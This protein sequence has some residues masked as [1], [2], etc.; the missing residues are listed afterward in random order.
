MQSKPR[1]GQGAVRDAQPLPSR[2][3]PHRADET[4]VSPFELHTPS[5][6]DNLDV[7]SHKPG[8]PVDE[9]VHPLVGPAMRHGAQDVLL[10]LGLCL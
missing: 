6:A 9:P 3:S 1:G 10:C 8:S 4:L 2:M 5:A 7:V